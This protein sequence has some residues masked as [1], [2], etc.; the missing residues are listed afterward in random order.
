M[1]PPTLRFLFDAIF[2]RTN[3]VNDLQKKRDQNMKL[4]GKYHNT[5]SLRTVNDV[6]QLLLFW[7]TAHAQT[8]L[9]FSSLGLFLLLQL[10][11]LA[12]NAIK[13]GQIKES[14]HSEERHE[15]N[16]REDFGPAG[17]G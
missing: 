16:L 14:N 2:D 11:P 5:N 4:N 13:G 10:F 3:E 17:G 9:P 1:P 12:T 7:N 15:A 6:H 8:I